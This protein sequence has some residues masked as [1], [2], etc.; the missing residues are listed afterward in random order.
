MG[1]DDTVMDAS[2]E[3]RGIFERICLW[4]PGYR[5]YRQKNIRRDV[6][7]EVRA[8][9]A[10]TIEES[11]TVLSTIQRGVVELGDIQMAKTVE[12][13]RVKTDTYLKNI[14]SAE[15]GY[16]GIWEVTKTKEGELEAVME[17]DAKLI[18]SGQ[19]LKKLLNS[20][21]DKVDSGS[22]DIKADIREVERFLDDLDAGL[23]TRM[24]VIR[25]LAEP[26]T[27]KESKINKLAN[28]FR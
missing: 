10:R 14:E 12:R 21:M 15:A 25:G 3:N 27:E 9:V 8:Q 23:G 4:I 18:E 13:I 11:K 28:R 16:S 24:Q 19:D 22:S 6:D 17:W 26:E 5:G 1:Y 7:K 20:I 2:K